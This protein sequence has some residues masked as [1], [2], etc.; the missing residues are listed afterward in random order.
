MSVTVCKGYIL[1]FPEGKLPHTA[2][3]FALH[4]TLTLSW[5]YM[6]QNGEMVLFPKSCTRILKEK[7]AAP[8]CWECQQLCRNENLE[9]IVSQIKDG[10]HKNTAFAYVG[11]SGLQEIL[12]C[13][14]QQ[15]EFHRL[16][17]LNQAKQLLRKAVTLSES[18]WLL[19]AI[20]SGKTQCVDQVISIGLH[21][22]KGVRG[23]LASM[24]AAAHGHY[25][26]KSYS[27]EEDMNT[28][29]IWWLSGNQVA[30]INQRSHGALSVSYLRSCS[31]IPLLIP[32]YSQPTVDD[33]QTNV[34]ATL[35]SV[36]SEIHGLV[37]GTALHTILMFDEIATEKRICWNPTS[38]WGFADSMR[39]GHW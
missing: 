14:N 13:K 11:F 12:Q 1:I 10:V 20:A 21:Q 17:G 23:L 32:S 4:E 24:M 19:M 37:K 6:A 15:V 38:S 29:L 2:Y 30:G 22:E 8:S 25:H 3:P 7:A 28:L 9:R 18:K 36:M 34:K 5:D 33:V 27:E 39:T 35:Q 26:P 16:C 31:I